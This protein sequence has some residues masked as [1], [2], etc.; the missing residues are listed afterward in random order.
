MCALFAPWSFGFCKSTSTWLCFEHAYRCSLPM[1]SHHA[2]RLAKPHE[3]LV[4]RAADF[5]HAPKSSRR[6]FAEA[7][8]G[9][10]WP[11][12][13]L[14]SAL[15]TNQAR[16][17]DCSISSAWDGRRC[18]PRSKKDSLFCVCLLLLL[19]ESFRIQ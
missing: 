7:D 13:V 14:S 1:Q 3:S 5:C 16:E 2:K 10:H 6:W 4:A 8:V 11:T 19:S 15:L 18:L 17:F 12:L 9:W